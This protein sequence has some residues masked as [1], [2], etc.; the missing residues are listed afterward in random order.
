MAGERL[1]DTLIGAGL[2]WGFSHVLPSWEQGRLP[3]LV[4]RLL[5]AQARYAHHVL[6][7]HQQHPRSTQRSHA[8]REVYDVLWLLAQALERMKKEPKR[9]RSWDAELETVL[10]RSHRL[11]SHLAGI[12]G[13]LTMRQ[14]ELDPALIQPALQHTE[15]ALESLLTL[16]AGPH[17]T[18]LPPSSGASADIILELPAAHA[19]PGPWLLHR[20]EQ[21]VDEARALAQAA[22][23]IDQSKAC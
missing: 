19:A 5:I 23:T 8:R 7:W 20:L 3:A 14:S 9:V 18:A 11:I 2:A 12:K 21:T 13:L 6:R 22:Q 15:H 16:Q 10:I 4:R 17:G 1:A